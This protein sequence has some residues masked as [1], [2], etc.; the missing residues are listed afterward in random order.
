MGKCSEIRCMGRTWDIGTHTSPK[1]WVPLFH[2][3]P[4]TQVVHGFSDMFLLFDLILTK[5]SSKYFAQGP[6]HYMERDKHLK[7]SLP[8]RSQFKDLS[9]P[10][11]PPKM[12]FPS[13]NRL[14]CGTKK[15]GKLTLLS[16]DTKAYLPSSPIIL[17]YSHVSHFSQDTGNFH[18]N[19][20]LFTK[21]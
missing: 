12:V 15:S 16:Q 5:W 20:G 3:I 9:I 7:M 10:Y 2:Q 6:F 13:N 4:T 19:S 1:L 14:L 11:F 21:I 18:G 17:V 8:S